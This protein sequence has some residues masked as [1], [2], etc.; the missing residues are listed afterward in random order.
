MVYSTEERVVSLNRNSRS[1]P[2]G[3]WENQFPVELSHLKTYKKM[4]AHSDR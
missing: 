2:E 4:N 1:S 3:R